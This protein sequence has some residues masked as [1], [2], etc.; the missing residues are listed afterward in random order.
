MSHNRRDKQPLHDDACKCAAT[1]RKDV[2]LTVQQEQCISHHFALMRR[3]WLA[4]DPRRGPRGN[5]SSPW[6]GCVVFRYRPIQRQDA[7]GSTELH[8]Y[9]PPVPCSFVFPYVSNLFYAPSLSLP[10]FPIPVIL[11]GNNRLLH[12]VDLRVFFRIGVELSRLW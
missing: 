6:V 1:I 5:G 3:L 10:R 11:S 8:F 12:A 7:V 2:T 4:K 9:V